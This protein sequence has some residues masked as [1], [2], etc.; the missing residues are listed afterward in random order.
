MTMLRVPASLIAAGTLTG[1]VGIA[2]AG[3]GAKEL[4]D[5]RKQVAAADERYQARVDESARRR[6]ET[7]MRAVAFGRLQ[8][9]CLIAVV[10]RM[11]DFLRRHEKQVRASERLLVD[12]IDLATRQLV[13]APGQEPAATVAWVTGAAGSVLAGAGAGAAVNKLANNYGVA[14]TGRKISTLAGAA[15]ERAAKAYLGGGPKASGGGGI[16]LGNIV[17]KFVV[18]GP[19]LLAGGMVTKGMAIKALADAQKRETQVNVWCAQ[20]DL[21][22]GSLT[23]VDQR[24]EELTELLNKLRPAAE[25]ELDELE[26]VPFDPDKHTTQLQRTMM[27]VLAVRDVATT[28]L[29]TTGGDLDEQSG[30]LTVKYRQMTKETEDD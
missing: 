27:L 10:L 15:K 1:A 26:A 24:A 18:V 29:L 25:A 28:P 2:L 17:N 11:S 20:L 22:D 19:S 9:E 8:E 4:D 13:R 5:A 14:G 12:G 6:A 21:A 23:A 7:N 3:K 16:A 30:T